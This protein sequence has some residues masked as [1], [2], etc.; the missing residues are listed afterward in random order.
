MILISLISCTVQEFVR[1]KLKASHLPPRVVE[2]WS[3]AAL[4]EGFVPFPKKLL[5]CLPRIF[6]GDGAVIELTAVL[7]IVDFRRPNLTRRPSVEFLSFLAGLKVL[8]FEA[9]LAALQAKGYIT[10]TRENEELTI[11]LKGLLD[12]LE[13]EAKE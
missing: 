7:A 3:R 5:R 10:V 2:K 11:S 9:A 1:Q 8:E 4:E 13:E 12:R 6:K